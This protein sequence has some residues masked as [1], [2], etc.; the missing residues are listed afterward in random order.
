[1]ALNKAY[2]QYKQN[3]I[4]TST[5]EELTLMLYNGLVKFIMQAQYG[6]NEK[7]IEKASNSLIKAQNI[8]VHFRKTLDMRYE[9]SKGLDQLYDYIYGRLVEANVKK[10]QQILDE[11]LQMAKELRD[12]W[13]QAIK[14]AKHPKQPNLVK[15]E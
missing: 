6:I 4:F 9:V 15:E 3:S 10:D 13:A 11:V 7:N 5:P 2:D 8:V 1:M 12:T 14:L